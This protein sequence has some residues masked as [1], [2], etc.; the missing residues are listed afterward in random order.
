MPEP[1]ILN[2]RCRAPL[3]PELAGRPGTART[4]PETDSAGGRLRTL[5]RVTFPVEE[6]G[7]VGLLRFVS[8]PGVAPACSLVTPRGF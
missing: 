6:C 1:F 4:A 2:R 7:R 5:A 3:K 8:R